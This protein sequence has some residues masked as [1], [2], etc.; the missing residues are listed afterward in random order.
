MP[1]IIKGKEYIL[2]NEGSEKGPTGQEIM[3]IENHFDDL[4]GLVLISSLS[5]QKF[6]KGYTKT[7]AMYSM[8]WIAMTRAGEVLSIADILKDYSIDDFDIR[9]EDD[10]PKKDL[11]EVVETA[12]PKDS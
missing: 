2:P 5:N 3:E 11:A 10:D 8:A 4:D 9:W 7:K 12:E 6:V 1:L